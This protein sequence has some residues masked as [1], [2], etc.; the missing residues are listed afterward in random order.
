[1][2][3]MRSSSIFKISSYSYSNAYELD[4]SCRHII[5]VI[6]ELAYSLDIMILTCSTPCLNIHMTNMSRSRVRLRWR[7]V[8]PS[9][10]SIS[11]TCRSVG[12]GTQGV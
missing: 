2:N 7:F 10:L 3:T 12:L 5:I 6:Y 1:M 9:G 11:F 8:V 4:Y